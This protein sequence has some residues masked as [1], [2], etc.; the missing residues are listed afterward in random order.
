MSRSSETHRTRQWLFVLAVLSSA[1][2]AVRELLRGSV[3]DREPR[4][5]E[6]PNKRVA[7]TT[8]SILTWGYPAKPPVAR[9]TAVAL[10]ATTLLFA[11]LAVSAGAG[12]DPVL[13]ETTETAT[14]TTEPEAVPTTEATP[15]EPVPVPEES[16][17]PAPQAP[18][19]PSA[20]APVAEDDPAPARS[21]S[22][23]AP[24]VSS[25]PAAQPAPA[26]RP[27]RRVPVRPRPTAEHE[28]A[29]H[30]GAPVVWLDIRLPDPTP[31]ARRLDR[32]FVY[33]LM[34]F[35][36]AAEVDWALVLGVVRAR[37]HGGRTPVDAYRLASL[38]TRLR[39]AGAARDERA[40]AFAV[41]G[42][43]DGADEAVALAR[44]NRAVGT[45][46]LVRGLAARK[47]VLVRRL[48]DDD[49]A[50]IYPAGREDLARGR[51]DVRVVVLLSYLAESFEG[52]TVTSLFSGHRLYARPGVVSA[53]AYGH[54][55]DVAA[56]GGVS[57][58]GNQ[59]PGGLTE[60]A[61]RSVLL[62]P[63]EVQPRQI[64]SLL[65]LGRASFPLADHHDHIHVG[66]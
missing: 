1:A 26:A 34:R 37:G 25:A 61:V 30:A 58:T 45:E 42:S 28:A 4:A 66:Y 51:I 6:P 29:T 32:W 62:L 7:A 44:Y 13:E 53:H 31:P 56:L 57:I 46:T 21:S 9:R 10:A 16:P 38:A 19:P 36:R 17:E 50:E 59:E 33:D 64:I 23:P 14:T 40:A 27:K 47:P 8:A 49:R 43:S 54:A 20:P 60:R 48:L 2:Y 24:H 63:A 3:D 11:G 65:G 5:T 12:D 22:A 39:D 41:M 55:V 18:S 35:S 15:V 52:V